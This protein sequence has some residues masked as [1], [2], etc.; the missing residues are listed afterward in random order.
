MTDS[1]DNHQGSRRRAQLLDNL[2]KMV[3]A[4]RVT[5]VEAERLRAAAKPG[6]FDDA[7]RDIRRRHVTAKVDAAVEDGSLSNQ[8]AEAILERLQNGE[9]PR[10]LRGLRRRLRPSAFPPDREQGLDRLQDARP[11]ES[12]AGRPSGPGGEREA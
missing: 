1:L 8:E 6:D 12:P 2:D 10:F 4:G 7:A 5:K 3:A 11:E 9:D